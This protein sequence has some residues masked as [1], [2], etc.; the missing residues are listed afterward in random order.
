MIELVLQIFI[1]LALLFVT[2]FFTIP[3][4]FLHCK[5]FK[6]RFL[7]SGVINYPSKQDKHLSEP[8]K[9]GLER[10]ANHVL[11]V[12]EEGRRKPGKLGL[13]VVEPLEEAPRQQVLILYCHGAS[14]NRGKPHRIEFYKVFQSLGYTVVTFD[15]RGFGD[16]KG[17]RASDATVEADCRRVLEWAVS[18]FPDCQV[19]VWGH[20]LGSG[21]STKFVHGVQSDKL[22]S[23]QKV[24]GLILESAFISAEE[25][26]KN[27]P[28][29][30]YWN[31][32]KITRGRIPQSM[33]GIFPTV[34]L[35]PQLQL[36]VFLVHAVDDKTIP[37]Q[38]S[39]VLRN[40]C[41]G[42]GK[43]DVQLHSAASGEHRFVHQDNEA[44][45]AAHQFI[46]NIKITF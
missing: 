10:T 6:Y 20:S 43:H 17:C 14:S 40:T 32:F 37:H 2:V 33:E 11:E 7:F 26:A 28:A 23:L 42:N 16:S 1:T 5:A 4:I 38:H 18:H 29:A 9:F 44:M 36:P 46:Q 45:L 41:S 25:A 21:I 39:V 8:S 24:R 35:L 34:C 13:W 30:K 31:Y 15:Y 3:Y 19:V 27:F 22:E 12:V